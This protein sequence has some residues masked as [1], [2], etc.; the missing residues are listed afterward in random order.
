MAEQQRTEG[1]GSLLDRSGPYRLLGLLVKLNLA[2]DAGNATI[3]AAVD[4]A[5]GKGIR[6]HLGMR[7]CGTVLAAITAAGFAKITKIKLMGRSWVRGPAV[8]AE[9]IRPV[10]RTA[11]ELI[12]PILTTSPQ[13][14]RLRTLYELGTC[15][16]LTR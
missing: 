1:K 13:A 10:V 5:S 9:P 14:G 11:T 3:A 12:R 7:P 4:V 2:L 6:Y 15:A 16:T 8:A